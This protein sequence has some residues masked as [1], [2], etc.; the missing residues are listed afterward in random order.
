MNLKI[1]DLLGGLLIAGGVFGAFLFACALDDQCSALHMPE[2]AI[3]KQYG[4]S[5]AK[6]ITHQ[7]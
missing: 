6:S 2:P 4:G 3:Q 7:R 1:S 5:Y